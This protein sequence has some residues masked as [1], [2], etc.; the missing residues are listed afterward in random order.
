MIILAAKKQK[1]LFKYAENVFEKIIANEDKEQVK[2]HI[3]K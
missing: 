2:N 1:D 3:I